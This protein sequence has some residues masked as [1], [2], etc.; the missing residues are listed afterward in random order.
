MM[1]I[2]EEIL[3]FINREEETGALLITGEWGS[4]KSY[5]IKGL[6]KELNDSKKE[7]L[8]VVSLFGIDSVASLVKAVKECYLEAN[9][10]LFTKTARKIG[11]VVGKTV[12]SGLKVAEAA[13]GGNVAVSAAKKGFSSILSL[14]LLDFIS[15]KNYI[16]RG[17]S[18]RKFVLVFD[19][20]ERCRINMIDLLGTVNE[21][22]ENRNIKTIILAAEDI[23]KNNTA[24][25]NMPLKKDQPNIQN[26]I[27]EDQYLAKSYNEF[28]EKVV[29]QTIK[30]EIS[31]ADIIDNM[32]NNYSESIDGYKKFLETNSHTIKQAFLESESCNLRFIKKIIITFERVFCAIKKAE[33]SNEFASAILYDFMIKNFELEIWTQS[34]DRIDYFEINKQTLEKYKAKRITVFSIH[35]WLETKQY[36]E[37]AIISDLKRICL[38][39]EI[40]NKDKVLYW[41]IIELNHSTLISGL[42][43]ALNDA[44]EGNLDGR[45]YVSLI[46]RLHFCLR[47]KI[48]L[49]PINY[50]K[51][52]SGIDK[53]ATRCKTMQINKKHILAVT[54][55]SISQANKNTLPLL[56]KLEYIDHNC[57]AWSSKLKIMHAIQQ[58]DRPL[59]NLKVYRLEVFDDE[60][61]SAF[62]T[63]YKKVDNEQKNYILHYLLSIDFIHNF[64]NT[65]NQFEVQKK[66]KAMQ[67]SIFNF[68]KL[69]KQIKA[70]DRNESDYIA[71]IILKN[72][73]NSICEKI[74]QLEKALAK[75][76]ND[77]TTAN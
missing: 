41:P 65:A 25:K 53:Y 24:S 31:Y 51:L 32:I 22:C 23:I 8:S 27:D 47:N 45:D 46:N 60:L 68:K 49:C 4:G 70:L 1:D 72:S 2:R 52:S 16:G 13:M 71:K 10:T 28:K 14:N 63:E 75:F 76:K 58:N 15:V 20:L 54:E 56:R 11:K 36:N 6:A 5:Y 44:Y 18:K 30:F 48:P 74:K 21:Y 12:D 17:K 61:L 55:N 42:Q 33:V 57:S 64:E 62:I 19:D 66:I 38:P 35:K 69:N 59:Y 26:V 7:Y 37:E 77:N 9:S 40:S 29:F 43:D 67:T 34:N 73:S 50:K 39:N 3:T